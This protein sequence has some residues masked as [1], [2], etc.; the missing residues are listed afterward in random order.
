[1]LSAAADPV[2]SSI[3]S[4]SC[5]SAVS[6]CFRD[7]SSSFFLLEAISLTLDPPSMIWSVFFSPLIPN[8]PPSA[9]EILS[10]YWRFV[11]VYDEL[12][13]FVERYGSYT[14]FGK[15]FFSWAKNRYPSSRLQWEIDTIIG[16]CAFQAKTDAM[17]M[18]HPAHET[19][20]LLSS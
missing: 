17:R 9:E 6:R 16:R 4:T 19:S 18:F 13:P 5:C 20:E 1:M 8:N 10:R 2:F 15:G 14:V 12:C 3:S 7:R 11:D